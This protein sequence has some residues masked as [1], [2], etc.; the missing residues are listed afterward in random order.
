MRLNTKNPIL[1]FDGQQDKLPDSLS[2]VIVVGDH[3]WLAS[4]EVT[5]VERLASGDGVTF[6][7]H[8]S[9]ALNDL[10][11]LPAQDTDFDQEID[12]EGL[13]EHDSFLWLVGSHSIKRKKVE[14][15]GTTDK[16][17]KRLAKTEVEGNRFI[18]ARI[19]LVATGDGADLE[20]ARS[21]VDP[22]D[23]ART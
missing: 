2:A 7:N 8:K 9:F 3:L 5:T 18:L 16:K 17:M 13:D 4:D 19:P 10:I 1:E 6:N 23:P 15:T 22:N 14:Q 20:L 12:I 21:V 11:D